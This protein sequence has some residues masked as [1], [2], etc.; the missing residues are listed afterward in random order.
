MDNFGS[1]NSSSFVYSVG[2]LP[3]EPPTPPYERAYFMDDL[4]GPIELPDLASS[5]K[6]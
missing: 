6:M 5:Q 4:M 3:A 1:L 2:T